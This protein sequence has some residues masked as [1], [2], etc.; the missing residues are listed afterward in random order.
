M[1]PTRWTTDIPIESRYELQDAADQV[2]GASHSYGEAVRMLQAFALTSPGREDDVF[3][4]S[5]LSA[6]GRVVAREDVLDV[7]LA[8]LT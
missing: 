1:R 5:L 7:E 8:S 6:N 2:I 4:V 3:L